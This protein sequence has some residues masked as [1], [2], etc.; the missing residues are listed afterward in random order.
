M[1]RF[2]FKLQ[3]VMKYRE[4]REDLARNA[5]EEALSA[6]H[7]QQAILEGYRRRRDEL[8]RVYDVSAGRTVDAAVF[9]LTNRHITQL[10]YLI[11]HQ[12]EV[13]AECQAEVERCFHEW[14]ERR[15]EAEVIRRLREKQWRLYLRESDKEEQKFQDDVFIARKVREM[16]G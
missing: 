8:M 11:E 7:R 13:V 5:Y 15:R 6:L 16:Q 4:L 2:R 14:T 10:L 12:L 1:K 3:T 9:H